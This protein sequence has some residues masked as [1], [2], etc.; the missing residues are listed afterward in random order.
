VNLDHLVGEVVATLPDVAVHRKSAR[1]ASALHVYADPE[2]VR[3]ALALL[4]TA[5][6]GAGGESLAVDLV[7]EG[8]NAG[9]SVA[10]SDAWTRGGWFELA[11]FAS[12]RLL[13]EDSGTLRVE[14]LNEQGVVTLLLPTSDAPAAVTADRVL[15]VD[16]DASVRDLLR[17]TLP[18][19]EGFELVEAH[20][21]SA[22]LKAVEA[23]APDLILLDWSMPGLSGADVLER[24]RAAGHRVPVVVLTARAEPSRRQLADELGAD[25]FLTKPFS[26]LELLEV[27]ERLHGRP[28]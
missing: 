5:A 26:P 22:A 2:R 17:A 7:G 6:A 11:A 19:G 18:V 9:L 27:V 1:S 4:L 20:D 14:H 23:A 3:E 21:G 13:G 10:V 15:L 16:D 25:S 28:A 8:T 24:L 12:R